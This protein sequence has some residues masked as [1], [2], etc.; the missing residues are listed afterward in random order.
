MHIKRCWVWT[1]LARRMVAGPPDC[2]NLHVMTL[3]PRRAMIVSAD[4]GEGHNSAGRALE[5]AMARTWPG[6][7]EQYDCAHLLAQ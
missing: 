6:R 7:L 3:V 5:E 4:I 1:G 2:N